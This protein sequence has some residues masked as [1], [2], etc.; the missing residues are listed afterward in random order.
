MSSRIQVFAP[1]TQPTTISLSSGINTKRRASASGRETPYEDLDEAFSRGDRGQIKKMGESLKDLILSFYKGGDNYTMSY[2]DKIKT[3][4]L[5]IEENI[6]TSEKKQ[7]LYKGNIENKEFKNAMWKAINQEMSDKLVRS[8]KLVSETLIETIRAHLDKIIR[9]RIVDDLSPLFGFTYNAVTQF[10]QFSE[11]MTIDR[12]NHLILAIHGSTTM[13]DCL[14]HVQA[15]RI[16]LASDFPFFDM[17]IA[18]LTPAISRDVTADNVMDTLKS[19]LVVYVP[20]TI[21]S[22]RF[23]LHV[24]QVL[25]VLLPFEKKLVQCIAATA[26]AA[27]SAAAAAAATASA[28]TATVVTAVIVTTGVNVPMAATRTSSGKSSRT[29]TK[30]GSSSAIMEPTP[31]SAKNAKHTLRANE[32]LSREQIL[33]RIAEKAMKEEMEHE[34]KSGSKKNHLVRQGFNSAKDADAAREDIGLDME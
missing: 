18:E 27:A 30:S 28:V 34:K 23:F 20:P 22:S 16:N 4:Q 3:I 21:G 1:V 11:S 2:N 26:A 19:K 29:T 7:D 5:F 13:D 14:T 25:K 24:A 33:E 15:A 6:F 17:S 10:N 32:K 12:I 31:Q 9:A 8:D